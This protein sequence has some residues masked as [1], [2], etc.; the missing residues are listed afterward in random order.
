MSRIYEAMERA[1]LL[2]EDGRPRSPVPRRLGAFTHE[3][4]HPYHSLVQSVSWAL[5]RKGR[6]AILVTSAIHGEGASTVARSLAEWE[7]ASRL[8]TLLI[9]ANLRRPIQHIALR[10]AK[11]AGLTDLATGNLPLRKALG[12]SPETGLTF[13]PAG[14]PSRSPAQ[15]LESVRLKRAM[16]RLRGSF[17]RIIIDGPPVT[18]YPDAEIL[19]HLV[20]EVILVVRAES[21]KWEVVETARMEL[22]R[23]GIHV[24]GAVLN[25]RRFHIPVWIYDRL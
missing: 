2:G 17:D 25:R 4:D 10:T 15:V 24:L 8:K 9:D 6:G 23:A 13:L 16:E 20:D 18:K 12:T 3:S 21:T 7:A 22:D 5:G 1:N 19:G 11:L 14:R